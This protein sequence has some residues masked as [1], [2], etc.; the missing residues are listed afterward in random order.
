MRNPNGYGSIR[1]LSG[2]RKRPYGVYITTEFKLAPSV[3]DIGFLAGILTPDL[4]DQVQAEYEAYKAK[5]P[6]KAK[7]VQ[8]CIGYYETR[9]DAMIALAEYNK[10][11][12]DIDKKNITFEQ[13]YDLLYEK[14]IKD[15]KGSSKAGY[16]TAYKKCDPLRKMRMREIKLAHLQNVVDQYS[17]KSKSTQNNIIVLYHAIYKLCME[18]DIIEKDYSSFVKITSTAEKKE[19]KPFSKQEIKLVWQNINWVQETPRENV[20]T[21]VPMMDSILVMLYTG[22]RI[23][24]LLEIKPSDLH[25]KERWIDLRGTKTK[26]ARR[27]VPIHK[28][29]MPL[30]EKRL[31]ECTGEYLFCGN[32]GKQLTYSRYKTMFYE[33]FMDEFK[34]E[35]TPHECRH[36]FA[37]IAAASKLN[38]ILLKK[39]IGHASADIT[40]SVYTHAYIE[41]LI[42]EIDKFNL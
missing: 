14:E 26:A 25:I 4:Y 16:E 9:P 34:I 2:K 11:P 7:Q 20:L 17:D 28:K 23:G 15:M 27:I 8:Q 38:P 32:D 6:L 40:E 5:Q 3:P 1:K 35:R 24:E 37:T 22:M 13:V 39:I 33:L 36:T 29:I 19:K 21:N 18:N 41:D 12:F 10:N 30:L 31:N 42:T